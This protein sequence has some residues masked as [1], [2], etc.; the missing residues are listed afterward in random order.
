MMRFSAKDG[1]FEH[2]SPEEWMAKISRKMMA[3]PIDEAMFKR[4][5]ITFLAR[6]GITTIGQLV[7]MR[8]VD[9]MRIKGLNWKSLGS[10]KESL[11]TLSLSLAKPTNPPVAR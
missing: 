1:S 9:I 5:V 2:L 4:R 10:I 11:A 3:A 8:E 6:S 7:R